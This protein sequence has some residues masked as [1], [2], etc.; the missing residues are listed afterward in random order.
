MSTR[1]GPI[2]GF[3]VVPQHS[4]MGTLVYVFVR[5]KCSIY[6]GQIWRTKWGTKFVPLISPQ[7]SIN[8]SSFA[9][10]LVP[11]WTLELFIV[12]VVDVPE[13]GESNCVHV[14]VGRPIFGIRRG[15]ARLGKSWFGRF[16]RPQ[17]RHVGAKR[18]QHLLN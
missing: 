11:T 10:F 4:W 7:I 8:S 9:I 6:V 2:A 14:S 13:M 15:M 5:R 1:R 3:L 16:R 17:D 12:D 18:V